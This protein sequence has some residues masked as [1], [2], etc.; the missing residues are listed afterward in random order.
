MKIELNDITVTV[1]SVK[2]LGPGAKHT[3]TL[4]VGAKSYVY[5]GD[6]EGLETFSGDL[7]DALEWERDL[8]EWSFRAHVVEMVADFIRCELGVDPTD[9][10]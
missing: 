7:W 3:I 4:K 2:G 6:R 5:D 1:P 10:S 9:R 8:N